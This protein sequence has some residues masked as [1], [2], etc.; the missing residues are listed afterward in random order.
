MQ[1][2]TI[3]MLT[4][5]D[6]PGDV[7]RCKE[8]GI[9]VYLVKPIKQSELFDA[10]ARAL[11]AT[12]VEDV[13]STGRPEKP[14]TTRKLRILLAEDSL[15][16][17]KVVL[18]ILAKYG[19][20]V[21][22]VENGLEA[23][24]VLGRDQ[25]D[26]VLMDVQMPKLDGLEATKR[27]RQQAEPSGH[28]IPIIAMTAH[29]MKGDRERCLAAGMDDY[30]PKPVRE[31]RLIDAIEQ[32]ITADGNEPDAAKDASNI[33]D[34]FDLTKA[35]ETVGGDH[36]L[37]MEVASAALEEIPQCLESVDAAL[38]Q[39]DESLLRR[40]AHTL[41]STLRYLGAEEAADLAMAIETSATSGELHEAGR[42]RARLNDVV[43]P[44]IR[45]LRIL[46]LQ[47]KKGS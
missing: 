27:I 47:N 8:L 20:H 10:I 13:L 6:Y 38:E 1:D 31:Q 21:D 40:V 16:N 29:A 33:A 37:L 19:H 11:S 39:N 32:A 42:E 35:L 2:A 41:K 25:Y 17:Q 3:M 30:V 5:Q 15:V 18:G 24:E 26:L 9:D 43:Q 28:H 23:L 7:A 34:A 45:S 4:S 46:I 36:H 12:P 14:S 44:V 22:V